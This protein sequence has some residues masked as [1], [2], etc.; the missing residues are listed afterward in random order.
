MR[1]HDATRRSGPSGGGHKVITA[2]AA[3]IGADIPP[4]VRGTKKGPELYR[5]ELGNLRGSDALGM[6]AMG[7][8]AWVIVIMAISRNIASRRA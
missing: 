8:F 3:I 1:L 5:P 4:G 2:P 7:M 6:C